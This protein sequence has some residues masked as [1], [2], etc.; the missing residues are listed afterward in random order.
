MD[1]RSTFFSLV[2]L[3]TVQA[4]GQEWNWSRHIGGE[5]TDMAYIAGIDVAGSV[6]IY[7]NYAWGPQPTGLEDLI[8]GDD[9]L[10]G[11]WA[12]FLAKFDADGDLMWTK[13]LR[14]P[15]GR[16]RL[17][18]AILDTLHQR[19][20]VVGRYNL[21]CVLDTITLGA[22]YG[23]A[24]VS[25]WDLE[26]HCNWARNVATNSYNLGEETCDVATVI[27]DH[28]GRVIVGGITS[29]YGTDWLEAR[30]VPKGSYLAAY[31]STGDTLWTRMVA[32]CNAPL[33]S[34]NPRSI[35]CDSEYVYVHSSVYMNSPNDTISI[36]SD[37]ITN[38][39]GGGYALY[40]ANAENGEIEWSLVD[41]FPGVGI[42]GPQR[43]AHSSSGGLYIAGGY[44]PLSE[45]GGIVLPSTNSYVN[46]YIVKYTNTGM[47]D[48]VHVYE[49]TIGTYHNC[50]VQ[51]SGDDFLVAG[52]LQGSIDWDGQEYSTNSRDLFIGLISASGQFI[53]VSSTVQNCTGTSIAARGAS[54]YMTGKFG[55]F[56]PYLPVTI[57]GTTFTSRGDADVVLAKHDMIT[58]VGSNR[59]VE[60]DALIIYAN[61]NRGS[62]NMELPTCFNHERSL[63]LRVYD[64]TGNLVLDRALDATGSAPGAD[65]F[66]AAPGLY[67]VTLT[68]G[69]RTFSGS[70]VVE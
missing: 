48:W 3:L 39:T 49:A 67:H 60:S 25:E 26:G 13:N 34:F 28:T 66:D 41:G 46:G 57:N 18:N 53:E 55:S 2:M 20:L 42:D 65:V 35:A 54:I 33:S 68:N 62:F 43:L 16:L 17:G 23:G 6:Y 36:D 30:P 37:N 31:T 64:G 10:H 52:Y 61:P 14:S 38:I 5:G 15:M 56:P 45:I 12:G 29:R 24:F 51:T 19:L 8:I 70:M 11:S 4:T 21:S 1:T 63:V 58:G 47:L 44:P 69:S 59:S 32:L 50:I 7:G 27:S 22:P 40:K 9:T